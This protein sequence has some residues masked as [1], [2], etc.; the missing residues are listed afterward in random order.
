MLWQ[1]KQAISVAAI[2]LVLF[3]GVKGWTKVLESKFHIFSSG[4]A[5]WVPALLGAFYVSAGIA[6]FPMMK[7]MCNMVPDRWGG[8]FW[9]VDACLS[10][11][12]CS[13]SLLAVT[14]YFVERINKIGVASNLTLLLLHRNAFLR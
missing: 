7:D 1:T 9:L 12:I 10:G 8:W 2:A 5:A 4:K 3:A 14:H 13:L 11:R 6:H